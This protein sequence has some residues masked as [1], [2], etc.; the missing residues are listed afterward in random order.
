MTPRGA[1][2]SAAEWEIG[3]GTGYNA[4]LMAHIVGETS[5]VIMV[6]IEED[7]VAATRQHLAA[8]GFGRVQWSAPTAATAIPKPRPMT[9]SFSW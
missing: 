3:A 9:G 8:A 1:I 7:L 6:D 5:Q 2:G 4:A